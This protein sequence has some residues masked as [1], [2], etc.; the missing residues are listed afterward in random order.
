MFEDYIFEKTSAAYENK[1]LLWDDDKILIERKYTNVFIDNGFRIV[2]YVGDLEFRRDY[3]ILMCDRNYK[4]LILADTAQ[5]VPYDIQKG[6]YVK[7]IAISSLF[8]G[9]TLDYLK[10]YQEA[11]LDLITLAYQNNYKPLN[12]DSDIRNFFENAVLAEENI[13]QYLSLLMD[14]LKAKVNEY[15]SYKDWYAIAELKAEINR[16]EA[17]YKLV[18]DTEWVS[19]TFS[20]W[21]IENFGKLT[22][23]INRDTPV[24]VSKAMEFMK[25]NSDKFIIIVMDGMSEF[26]WSILK[27]SFV[28]ITYTKASVFAMI[29]TVTSVSRQCLLS[30]K[31]P[32]NLINPWSQAQEKKEFLN[33]AA[34][35]GYREN[36]VYYARGYENDIR[37]SVKCATIIINDIDDMVH[38]QGQ[39][40][41]GMYNGV[42]VMAQSGELA[43]MVKKYLKQG[44]DVYITADHGNTPCEGLGLYRNA[45]VETTTR[46][47]R[48]MVLNSLADKDALKEKYPLVEYPQ[49]YLNK[50]Y[51]YLICE[52]QV[53]Y[54]VKGDKVMSHGGITI[55]EVVVPFIKIM[56]R[57]NNG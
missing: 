7:N 55:D 12:T 26:D 24:L 27:A 47:R 5:Y 36:Q 25:D 19:H 50:D 32:V 3:G 14:E 4:L 43:T 54:D 33:C 39:Q 45:G 38:G 21:V 48:M 40:R 9:V 22:Q 30:N 1:L 15:G 31:M 10:E 34:E 51:S 29:P 28:D 52:G 16:L 11:N 8:N 53:S 13:K 17:K 6:C 18:D 20:E 37:I 41:I 35:L 23:E 42:S 49:Y 46:S 57:D 44:F 56:A 2:R